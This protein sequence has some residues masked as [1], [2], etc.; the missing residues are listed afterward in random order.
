MSLA[1]QQVKEVKAE[2]VIH[3]NYKCRCISQ[4]YITLALSIVII[5]LVVFAIL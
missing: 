2:K 3:E 1:L 5:G 4:F